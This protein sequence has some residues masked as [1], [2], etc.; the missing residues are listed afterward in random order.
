MS[1]RTYLGRDAFLLAA[2][3]LKT[4]DVECPELG[5]WVRVRELTVAEAATIEVAAHEA[6]TKGGLLDLRERMVALAV[7]S[8]Q[9]VPLFTPDDV[10]ALS[11]SGRAVIARLHDVARRLS[12][13]EDL[14]TTQGNSNGARPGASSSV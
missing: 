11:T 9:G 13:Y 7:V 6:S 1:E 2:T 14:E 12:G 10:K 8:A 3:T 4:E 5:G